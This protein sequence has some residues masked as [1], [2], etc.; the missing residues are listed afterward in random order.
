MSSIHTKLDASV[1]VPTQANVV[2]RRTKSA[3]GR[4]F[5]FNFFNMRKYFITMSHDE[6]TGMSQRVGRTIQ[7]GSF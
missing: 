3:H 6:R 7:I 1:K 4:Q 2:P 5:I